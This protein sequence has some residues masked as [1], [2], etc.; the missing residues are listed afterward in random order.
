MAKNK[1]SG[2]RLMGFGHRVYKNFDPR[3]RV[4]QKMCYKV[5][6]V[7]GRDT[8]PLLEIAVKLEEKALK[9]PYFIERKLYPNVDFYTGIVYKALDI[10]VNMFTVMFAIARSIGWIA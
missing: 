7:T 1:S 2:F 9:D 10:P 4:M 6:E 5:L 3:S 8:M